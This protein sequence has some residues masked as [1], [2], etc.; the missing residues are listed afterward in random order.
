MR[1]SS[2]RCRAR[3]SCLLEQTVEIDRHV[4][5]GDRTD[6]AAGVATLGIAAVGL[7]SPPRERALVWLDAPDLQIAPAL[8]LQQ[9]DLDVVVAGRWGPDLDDQGQGL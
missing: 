7:S 5:K 6:S 2:T 8:I 4:R 9:F 3:F 1:A